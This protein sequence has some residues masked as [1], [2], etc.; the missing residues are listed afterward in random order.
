MPNSGAS[1]MVGTRFH[2]EVSSSDASLGVALVIYEAGLLVVHTLQENE[3]LCITDV[4]LVSVAGGAIGLYA[5]TDAA[6]KRIVKAT[7]DAGGG[8]VRS[9]CV[10]HVC[11]AGVVPKVVAPEGQVDCIIH[12]YIKQI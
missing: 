3:Q 6:G 9:L 11:P 12:G 5:D 8:I 2:A 10:P 4:D 1:N 7:V